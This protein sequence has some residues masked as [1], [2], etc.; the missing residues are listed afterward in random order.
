MPYNNNKQDLTAV[1]S[2]HYGDAKTWALNCGYKAARDCWGAYAHEVIL[3]YDYRGQ[4]LDEPTKKAVREACEAAST[5]AVRALQ[6]AE[7][8]QALLERVEPLLKRLTAPARS[9]S[10]AEFL[11]IQ[12]QG[13][14]MLEKVQAILKEARP[15]FRPRPEEE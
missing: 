9:M 12:E 11:A 5:D 8:M 13:E 15:I 2:E 4:R 1:K 14:I 6:M 3:L 10:L 7:N